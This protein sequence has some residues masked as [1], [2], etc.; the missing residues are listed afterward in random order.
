[1]AM[2]FDNPITDHGFVFPDIASF[3]DIKDEPR[4]E[5]DGKEDIAALQV[6]FKQRDYG[7]FTNIVNKYIGNKDPKLTSK[8]QYMFNFYINFNDARRE[9][10]LPSNKI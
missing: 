4:F 5:G 7:T 2:R 9:T 1:M 3:P 10:G 8:L 6:A